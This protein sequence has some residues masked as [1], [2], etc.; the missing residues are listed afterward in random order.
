[1]GYDVDRGVFLASYETV[2]DVSGFDRQGRV[3]SRWGLWVM[4]CEEGSL[5]VGFRIE[6]WGNGVCF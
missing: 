6:I 2:R 4:L 1:M 3:S 5:A